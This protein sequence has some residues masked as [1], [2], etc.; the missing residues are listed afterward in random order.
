MD[1]ASLAALLSVWLAAIASPG[2]DVVQIT[3][4][5]SRSKSDGVACALGIMVGN[6]GWIA[7]S[8]LGVAAL[9][10]TTPVV[11]TVMK[12]I[13]GAYLLWI[14]ISAIRAGLDAPTTPSAAEEGGETPAA[15]RQWWASLRVGIMTNLSNPKAVLFFGAVFAQFVRPG[16]TGWVAVGIALLLIITGLAWFVGFALLVQKA[17]SFLHQ[18]AHLIE[19]V[20]GGVFVILAAVMLVG[21][22]SELVG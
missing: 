7:A 6:T 10:S 14:G 15:R 8:L 9:V 5:G 18:R 4:L 21:G 11:L 20:S 3:R 22:V 19:L 12:L 16:M 1:L 17:A 13:G 2:P